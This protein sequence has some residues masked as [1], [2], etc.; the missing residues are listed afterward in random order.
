LEPNFLFV[1]F[2]EGAAGKFLLSLLMGS[3]SVAHFNQ[4]IE[5]NK[6]NDQLL[7]YVYDSFGSFDSWLKTEPNPVTCWNIHWISNKLSRGSGQTTNDFNT[8]LQTDASAYFWKSVSLNKHILI[9]NN[10]IVPPVA[11]QNLAP[12][13][14]INDRAALRFLRK[15]VW[16]KH[17]GVRSNKIYLKINDPD[18]YPEPTKSIMKGF[19]NPIFVDESVFSF[20]RRVIWDNP[21]TK[22]F[23]SRDNFPKNS[24]FINLSE[25][26]DITKLVPAIDLLCNQVGTVPVNH[27]YIRQAHAHWIRLH[28]FKF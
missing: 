27:D 11:Y 5:E 24:I 8:Q 4:S 1:R 19:D 3:Q 26:L 10:K 16:F 25:I 18:M 17:Y 13:V 12:V 23:A 15:S 22:F 28:T 2:N 6:T 7:T 14:I 9:V 20:Y 21:H